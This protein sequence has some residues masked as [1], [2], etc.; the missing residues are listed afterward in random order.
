MRPDR[1]TRGHTR[2]VSTK[3]PE[4]AT[5][6]GTRRVPPPPSTP[7][8]VVLAPRHR[9]FTTAHRRKLQL[10]QESQACIYL[11]NTTA[12]QGTPD[13]CDAHEDHAQE[14]TPSQ[15]IATPTRPPPA[16]KSPARLTARG[17]SPASST[18]TSY[19]RI[20]PPTT[21]PATT[22]GHPLTRKLPP[23]FPSTTSPRYGSASRL[24]TG[25][26]GCC[27]SGPQA[28]A[29]QSGQPASTKAA[30]LGQG[31]R[32]FLFH[33]FLHIVLRERP[34]LAMLNCERPLPPQETASGCSPSNGAGTLS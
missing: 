18:P 33:T 29:S 5:A 21:S 3:R 19:K 2:A 31:V 6:L 7:R 1:F 12:S 17:D 9:A 28:P 27:I 30:I 8:T 25:P 20:R 10:H 32:G 22:K 13:L 26:R 34:P 23:L 11:P 15:S 14:Q 16:P 24:W 4:H